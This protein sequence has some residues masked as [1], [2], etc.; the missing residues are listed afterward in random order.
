LKFRKWEIDWANGELNISVTEIL[1]NGAGI[2]ALIGEV[3]PAGMSQHMGMN[4]KRQ[5]RFFSGPPNQMADGAIAERTASFRH[6]DIGK[7]RMGS[8]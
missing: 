5:P 1:L 4:R 7:T 6:K 8:L 2:N 3:K